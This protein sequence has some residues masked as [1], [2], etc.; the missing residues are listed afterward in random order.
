MTDLGRITQ[1]ENEIRRK[2]E[3][4][5]FKDIMDYEKQGYA[6]DDHHN[7]VGLTLNEL[8]LVQLPKSLSSFRHLKTF[9]LTGNKLTD[10]SG[11]KGLI[12]LTTL[13]LTNNQ[14][15]RLLFSQAEIRR[16]KKD[17]LCNGVDFVFG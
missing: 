3:E 5:D 11:L 10:V 8:K 14:L 15:S 7:V 13:D 17:L 2:L 9:K 6:L 12:N 16:K 4:R 1:L